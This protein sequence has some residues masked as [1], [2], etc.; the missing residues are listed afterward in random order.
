[1]VVRGRRAE[2]LAPASIVGVPGVAE[3]QK[4]L[5]ISARIGVT[6][7]QRF[8][9]KNLR[10]VARLVRPAAST[11]RP[12]S[13][14]ASR[15]SRRPGANVTGVPPVHVQRG[16][17]D[18]GVAAVDARDRRRVTRAALLADLTGFPERLASAARAAAGRPVPDGE[19][20]RNEVVRH[21]IAVETEVHQARLADL[22]TQALRAGS[23]RSQVRGRASRSCRSMRCW[24]GSPDCGPRRARRSMPS[25]RPAGR[26]RARTPPGRVG[27]RG[28]GPERG[29]PRRG[30]PR[31]SCRRLI[32]LRAGSGGPGCRGCSRP[33]SSC[34]WPGRCRTRSATS[35]ARS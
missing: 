3:P 21:L 7:A 28:P 6:D 5:A 4:L 35:R 25:M 34:R 26:A 20:G 1:M 12:G 10:F 2:A 9:V 8:L 17:G 19:W 16:R 14:R 33:T 23:G 13:W 24:T 15:R 27:R 32:A 18:G 29:R 30:A 22:A 11:G 31:G